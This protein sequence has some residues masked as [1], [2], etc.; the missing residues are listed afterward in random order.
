MYLVVSGTPQLS[1]GGRQAIPP[2][3]TVTFQTKNERE[4]EIIA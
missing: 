3:L 4:Y 1:L 2:N